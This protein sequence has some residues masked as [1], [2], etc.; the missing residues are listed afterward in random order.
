[1]TRLEL[2]IQVKQMANPSPCSCLVNKLSLLFTSLWAA[3]YTDTSCRK[4]CIFRTKSG[5]VAECFC[6]V[7]TIPYQFLT[8]IATTPR[9]MVHRTRVAL[10]ECHV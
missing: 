3:G 8:S 9:T 2:G 1:M 4:S 5:L 6:S 7:S 10:L